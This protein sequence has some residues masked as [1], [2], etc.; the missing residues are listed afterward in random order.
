MHEK[1]EKCGIID[2]CV[3]TGPYCTETAHLTCYHSE[4]V[5]KAIAR[6]RDVKRKLFGFIKDKVQLLFGYD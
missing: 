4:R 6:I 5:K 2:R 3:L 1:N